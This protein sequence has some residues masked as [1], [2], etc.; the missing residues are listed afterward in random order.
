M[1]TKKETKTKKE[2]TLKRKKIA[3][4]VGHGLHTGASHMRIHEHPTAAAIARLVPSLLD[5]SKVR[6]DVFAY[7]SLSNSEGLAQGCEDVNDGDYDAFIDLHCDAASHGSA[8]GG[9][10]IY[11]STAGKKLAEALATPLCEAMPG[12]ADKTKLN[13]N[14][15]MLNNTKPP[16]VIVEL[17]FLTNVQ[18]LLMLTRSPKTLSIAL[19]KGINAY[20]YGA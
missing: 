4:R 15:R 5:V 8:R 9:H 18:D 7:P 14:F 13:K 17:G 3:I 20:F 10:V 1:T 11:C 6:C 12:R 2:T 19:T 16:A